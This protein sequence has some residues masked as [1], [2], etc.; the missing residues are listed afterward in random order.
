[1][2]QESFYA[3]STDYVDVYAITALPQVIASRTR[4]GHPDRI[5]PDPGSGT[6][7]FPDTDCPWQSGFDQ[8]PAF[9]DPD[10]LG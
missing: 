9:Q 2:F 8:D 7:F 10:G 1:M 5:F 6:E 4:V 3:N